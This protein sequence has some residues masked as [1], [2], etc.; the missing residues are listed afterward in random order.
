MPKKPFIG[1]LRER[2]ERF[3][4]QM[5]AANRNPPQTIRYDQF[6]LPE[7]LFVAGTS[8]EPG[9]MY[10]ARM[11]GLTPDTIPESIPATAIG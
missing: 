2:R 5:R 3:I 8:A 1:P 4:V 9:Y 7:Y 11:L 10:I 6:P